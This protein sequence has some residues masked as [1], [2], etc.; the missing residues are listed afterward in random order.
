L[1]P[2]F[3][4]S[5]SAR[6]TPTKPERGIDTGSHALESTCFVKANV[7][8]RHRN[9]VAHHGGCSPADP[10]VCDTDSDRH[11]NCRAAHDEVVAKHGSRTLGTD[12]YLSGLSSTVEMVLAAELKP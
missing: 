5:R 6:S 12:G 10:S 11:L 9:C 3:M 7:W 8:Y 2:K 1:N 4:F